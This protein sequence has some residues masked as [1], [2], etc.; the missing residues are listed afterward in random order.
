MD[1]KV[2]ISPASCNGLIDFGVLNRKF[3]HL[4]DA[5]NSTVDTLN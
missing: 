1:S 5:Q 3:L 2:T 4:Y